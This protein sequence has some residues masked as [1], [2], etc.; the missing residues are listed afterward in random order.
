MGAVEGSK[1]FR[2]NEFMGLPG[3]QMKRGYH[4]ITSSIFVPPLRISVLEADG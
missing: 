3:K 1:G 2:V 4:V